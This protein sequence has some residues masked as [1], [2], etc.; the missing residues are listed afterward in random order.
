MKKF[1]FAIFLSLLPISA[2]AQSFNGAN[3]DQLLTAVLITLFQGSQNTPPLR[4]Y[5]NPTR[6]Q[7]TCPDDNVVY[8]NTSTYAYYRPDNRYYGNTRIQGSYICE[9]DALNA[10]GY[11]SRTN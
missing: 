4:I 2:N 8:M 3:G 11:K 5:D 1:V 10:G 9:T 6:A 7:T